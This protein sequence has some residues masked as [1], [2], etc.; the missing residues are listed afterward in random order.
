MRGQ[1]DN[2]RSPGFGFTKP[3]VFAGLAHQ[4]DPVRVRCFLSFY[5]HFAAL[6]RQNTKAL[7]FCLATA[8]CLFLWSVEAHASFQQGGGKLCIGCHST[9]YSANPNN[10]IHAAVNGRDVSA[11]A[12]FAVQPGT[13]FE[14]D[15]YFDTPNDSYTSSG[16]LANLPAGWTIA[17]GTSNT[18]PPAWTNWNSNWDQTA[19]SSWQAATAGYYTVEWTSPNPW[20]ADTKNQNTA[21]NNGGN[22]AGGTDLDGV[23]NR[24][25]IDARITPALTEGVY[26]LSI[27]AIVKEAD[28]GHI[29]KTYTVTVDGTAPTITNVTSPTTDGTYIIDDVVTVTVTFSEPVY[30]TG[31]PTLLLETGSTD[32]IATYAGG[33]GTNTLAFTYVVQP[34]DASSDLDYVST[35]SLALNGGAIRDAAGNNATLTLFS[36]GA[37]GSLAYNKALVIDG[38][39]PVLTIL[40]SSNK[41]NAQPGDVIEYTVQVFNTGVGRG[42]NVVVRDS[43]NPFISLVSDPYGNGTPFDFIEGTPASNLLPGTVT[44]TGPNGAWALPMLGQMNGSNANFTLKYQATIK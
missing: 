12:G 23:A 31:T 5:R 36:P 3:G 40:K 8:A 1:T 43:M 41:G 2:V 19:G 10:L 39:P 15:Y 6:V 22:C 29:V 14:L 34:G 25:G 32:R 4:G 16:V 20:D 13:A 7:F 27:Y 21:C 38:R 37:V 42:K 35:G 26:S 18:A 9:D 44:V 33:S 24:M 28:K 11:T 17:S 30:V